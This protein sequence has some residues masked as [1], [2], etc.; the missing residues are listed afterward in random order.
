MK[1]KVL[2]RS[3]RGHGGETL[4]Y[5]VEMEVSGAKFFP[6]TNP[7]YSSPWDERRLSQ[8]EVNAVLVANAFG[9]VAEGLNGKVLW[10][11]SVLQTDQP[12]A[13]QFDNDL[14]AVY[15]ALAGGS[16][17][18]DADLLA[19]KEI[20]L[21]LRSHFRSLSQNMTE[22]VCWSCGGSETVVQREGWAREVPCP[23][24]KGD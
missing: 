5:A 3:I 16:A 8:A 19:A 20:L 21:K 2:E 6:T 13:L 4:Q 12:L 22:P 9:C 18:S 14:R 23:L 11:P 7:E 1:V 17:T 24:C 15:R 10:E